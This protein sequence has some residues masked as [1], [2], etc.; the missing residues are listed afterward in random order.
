MI[1]FK[2][3]KKVTPTKKCRWLGSLLLNFLFPISCGKINLQWGVL[4]QNAFRFLSALIFLAVNHFVNINV[5]VIT[6]LSSVK[7][8]TLSLDIIS[9]ATINRYLTNCGNVDRNLK[10]LLLF[11][12]ESVNVSGNNHNSVSQIFSYNNYFVC[13]VHSLVFL[14][15]R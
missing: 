14:L 4:F 10:S 13:F 9:V 12:V 11:G 8:K 15:E 2:D 7:F 6:F 3:Q 1:W 5:T